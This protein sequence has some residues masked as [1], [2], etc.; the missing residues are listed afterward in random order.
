MRYGHNS[1]EYSST[2]LVDRDNPSGSHHQAPRLAMPGRFVMPAALQRKRKD[3][4]D[5][6][7]ALWYA[8]DDL[9]GG[10]LGRSGIGSDRVGLAVRPG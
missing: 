2:L 9:A 4:H 5:G 8:V 7:M 3:E 10:R 6:A 1:S